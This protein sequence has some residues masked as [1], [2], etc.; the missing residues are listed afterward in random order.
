[1]LCGG[2]S[3]GMTCICVPLGLSKFSYSPHGGQA[4]DWREDVLLNHGADGRTWRSNIRDNYLQNKVSRIS[5]ANSSA[6][7]LLSARYSYAYQ[8]LIRYQIPFPIFCSWFA[9]WGKGSRSIPLPWQCTIPQHTTFRLR[10]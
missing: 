9:W 6:S 1:M 3:E 10:M 5:Q 8:A 4:M 2:E 7:F